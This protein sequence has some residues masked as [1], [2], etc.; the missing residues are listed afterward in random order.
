MP[1]SSKQLIAELSK[2]VDPNLSASIVESY[3]EM[4]QRY[5]AGDWQPAELD[6]GRLCEAVSRALYQLDCGYVTH[7]ELPG[8]L[9]DWLEDFNNKR[10]HA[11]KETDRRHFCRAIRLVYKFRSDRG[12]VHISTVYSANEMD[13]V[14][15][16]HVGKWMFAEFLRLAWNKDRK[17]IAETIA[18]IIQLEHPIIHEMD[19]TPLVLDHGVSA[20]EEVL[21]L[22]GHADGHKMQKSELTRQAKN[23]TANSVG[24]AISRLAKSNEIRTTGTAGE[25]ALT[26]KGQKR[27]I[28]KIV[29]KLKP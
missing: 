21:M 28:Q 1:L 22:L 3:V 6:G 13:S 27:V 20:P 23:N 12:A 5:F 19:G 16:L 25:I 17:I 14:L 24:T 10:P 8:T 11:L 9:C 29:P 26:P 15:M 2:V 7:A 18:D 4:Q